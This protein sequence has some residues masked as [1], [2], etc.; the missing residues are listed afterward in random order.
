[1]LAVSLAGAHGDRPHEAEA[2][3]KLGECLH[4]TSRYAEAQA[5]FERAIEVC[6]LLGDRDGLWRMTA[7]VSNTYGFRGLP[8]EG[9]SRLQPILESPQYRDAVH[10]GAHA[11]SVGMVQMQLT[12]LYYATGRSAQAVTTS[13]QAISSAAS[14]GDEATR[15]QALFWSQLALASA[16]RVEGGILVTKELIPW[17]R[18]P[19]IRFSSRTP[20]AWVRGCTSN[21]AI[22]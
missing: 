18:L 2:L 19:A 9:L 15:T 17:L 10:T 3:E 14:A 16:G 13:K 12:F 21:E 4:N 7:Q 11:R 8:E 20:S 22:L 6:E 5:V 1:M